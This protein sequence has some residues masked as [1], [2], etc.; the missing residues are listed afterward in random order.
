MKKTIQLF[1]FVIIFPSFAFSQ[2]TIDV[3]AN[4]DNLPLSTIS[5]VKANEIFAEM[6]TSSLF[7]MADCNNCEDRANAIGYILHKKGLNVAKFWLFG[8][9]KISSSNQV[10]LLQS[11]KCG[12]WGYHIAIGLL[13]DNN[14]TMDTVIIDPAT[15]ES[16]ITLRNW[17]L[18]LIQKDRTGYLAIKDIKYYTYPVS[19]NKFQANQ[20]WSATDDDFWKTACGL[21]GLKPGQCNKNR[22]AQRIRAKQQLLQ[23]AE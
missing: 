19:N 21:C 10:Y 17:A 4:S 15:Q 6:N 18:P 14:G 1:F 9:G 20:T 5:M 22:F 3:L 2:K 13:L 11:A 7:N 16:A 23:N 12:T 8:E